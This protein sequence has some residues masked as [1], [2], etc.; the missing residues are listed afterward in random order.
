MFSLLKDL[1][2]FVAQVIAGAILFALLPRSVRRWC[3]RFVRRVIY[4]VWVAG[5]AMWSD[6]EEDKKDEEGGR[7]S[8]LFNFRK[9]D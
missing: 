3:A 5:Q 6:M 4:R 2:F 7:K 9:V 1:L 8:K